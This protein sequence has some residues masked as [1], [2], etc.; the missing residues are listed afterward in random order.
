MY[1]S[2]TLTSNLGIE[3]GP[4]EWRLANEVHIEFSHFSSGP[5][6]KIRAWLLFLTELCSPKIHIVGVLTPGPQNLTVFGDGV[7]EEVIKVKWGHQGLIQQ[8]W[9]PY[10]KR[11]WGHRHAQRD[12]HVRTRGEDGVHTP[13]RAASGKTSPALTWISDVKP[14]G[15]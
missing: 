8:H 6:G 11:R 12:D 1:V 13:R 10:E 2:Q 14:P 4:W 9:G 5:G 7:F 3:M 15:R